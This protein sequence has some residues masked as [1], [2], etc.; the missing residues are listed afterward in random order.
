MVF[1]G[2][3]KLFFG[4]LP[5]DMDEQKMLELLEPFGEPVQTYIPEGKSFAI[6]HMDSREK[7]Y[8]AMVCLNGISYEGKWLR[9]RPSPDAAVWVGDLPAVCSNELLYISFSRW[10]HVFRAIVH[11]DT[12]GK[13][14]GCGIVEFS[15][16]ASAV[17]CVE[18]CTA[19]PFCLT[20]TPH[21]V[22]VEPLDYAESDAGLPAKD[23]ATDR[24]YYEPMRV[25]CSGQGPR[26]AS[27]AEPIAMEWLKLYQAQHLA[28]QSLK[29]RF[30]EE[31]KQLVV[32]MRQSIVSAA[33]DR[34][35]RAAEQRKKQREIMQREK[36]LSRQR[37]SL[38]EEELG[39]SGTLLEEEEQLRER[40][41]SVLAQQR[42][43]EA[44]LKRLRS[45]QARGP[46]SISL[47]S[48]RAGNSR[49][50]W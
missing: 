43:I 5:D 31:R 7:A 6:I 34:K 35:S 42:A 38:M 40:Q 4:G 32:D 11:C 10:G 27:K 20:A 24:R 26:L 28:K 3:C 12:R 18:A 49:S 22:R 1:P 19:Q 37:K 21:P 17:E 36:Y 44:K 2:H 30:V 50:G 25:E 9:V 46:R 41:Q 39:F 45:K 23:M 15:R 8:K 16:K 13:S 29:E 33:H 47:S 48:L 14:L